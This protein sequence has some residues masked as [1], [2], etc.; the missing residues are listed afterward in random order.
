M[1]QEKISKK[2]LETNSLFQTPSNFLGSVRNFLKRNYVTRSMF[3]YS[4]GVKEIF[5]FEGFKDQID[6]SDF[7]ELSAHRNLDKIPF[8]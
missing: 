5:F 7:L 3:E 8:E 2:E 6:E 4:R 1:S